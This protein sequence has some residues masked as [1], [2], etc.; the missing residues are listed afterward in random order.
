MDQTNDIFAFAFLSVSLFC[1]CCFFFMRAIAKPIPKA[2]D[3]TY[4]QQALR[5]KKS[6][7]VLALGI[8]TLTF[9]AG[10]VVSF[11]QVYVEI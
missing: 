6:Y 8:M 7:Q 5:V 4:S 10:L 3:T 1:I 9:L 11:V 2:M